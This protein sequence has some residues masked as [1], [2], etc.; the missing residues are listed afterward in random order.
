M[1]ARALR[2]TSLRAGRVCHILRVTLT[3]FYGSSCANNG[4]GCTQHPRGE[5][6]T[7]VRRSV[8]P[9]GEGEGVTYVRRS[10]APFGEGVTYV[11]RSIAPFEEGVTYVRRSV[12]PFEE[13]VTYVRRSITPFGEGVTYVRRSEVTRC[14][15]DRRCSTRCRQSRA[16]YPRPVSDLGSEGIQRS[17][18]PAIGFCVGYILSSLQRLAPRPAAELPGVV[19]CVGRCQVA[20]PSVVAA[21]ALAEPLTHTT[22]WFSACR[23]GNI[24]D[25]LL[26]TRRRAGKNVNS[27]GAAQ[28]RARSSR[29]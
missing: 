16:T 21:K 28:S 20:P 7:Y 19:T 11:R 12:A 23:E 1:A 4:K 5:G 2:E 13:G 14:L 17:P 25:E 27:S 22:D 29:L 10:V 8:A 3:S 6:V 24:L 15:Q 18:Q 9:L 26:C